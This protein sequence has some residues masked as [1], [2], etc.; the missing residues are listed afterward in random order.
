MAFSTVVVMALGAVIILAAIANYLLRRQISSQEVAFAVV[1]FILI[2]APNWSSIL[3]DLG[4]QKIEIK[5]QIG[6]AASAS[7]A[8][9]EQVEVLSNEVSGIRSQLLSLSELLRTQQAVPSGAAQQ[10]ESRLRSLPGVDRASLGTART[11]LR[12]LR[13]DLPEQR[14]R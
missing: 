10:I 6:E 2:T 5:R 4:G 13:T 3:I 11:T 9:A 12:R 7:D 8:V 1:G 14:S